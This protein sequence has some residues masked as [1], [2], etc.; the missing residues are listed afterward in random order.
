MYCCAKCGTPNEPGMLFC[1]HCG[2]RLK[3]AAA[4]AAPAQPPVATIPAPGKAPMASLWGK[5]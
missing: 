4:A 5:K 3:P 1:Q 2:T